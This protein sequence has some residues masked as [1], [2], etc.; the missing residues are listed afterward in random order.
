M[1]PARK[2]GVFAAPKLHVLQ[3]FSIVASFDCTPSDNE[4]YSIH[5]TGYSLG[6]VHRVLS[7]LTK[8]TARMS[9]EQGRSAVPIVLQQQ[10]TA[11]SGIPF[12][13]TSPETVA[14]LENCGVNIWI[15][16]TRIP[17]L[18]FHCRPVLYPEQ[19]VEILQVHCEALKF[20]VHL[21]TFRIVQRQ[22]GNVHW[23]QCSG[24][25]NMVR[26]GITVISFRN[27]HK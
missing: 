17:L 24:W 19:R 8:D 12:G 21:N 15:L 16:R 1:C 9:R 14:A 10:L 2:D 4:V 11:K 18:G 27:V 22:P 6:G 13:C 7:V 5:T 25:E 20:Q 3:R 26:F 23:I